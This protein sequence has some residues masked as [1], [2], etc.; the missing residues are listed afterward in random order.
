[1]LQY[2][3]VLLADTS[4]SYCHYKVKDKTTAWI[5]LANLKAGILFAMKQNLM[6]QFVY[7]DDDLPEGYKDLIGNIDHTNIMSS[8]APDR[9]R[10]DVLVTDRA[11]DLASACLQPDRECVFILHVCRD[12]LPV[13]ADQLV[14][15]LEKQGRVNLV[16][17]DVEQWKETEFELYRSALKKLS[18]LV[19]EQYHQG[20]ECQLNVL[21]DRIMLTGMN[22]CNAGDENI[23][24]GPDGKFYIC[25]AFYYEK[26]SSGDLINGLNILNPRLYKLPSAPICRN[27][28]AFQCK[29]CVWMNR[30]LT[31]EVNTP[32]HEQCVISHIERNASRDLWC[33]LHREGYARTEN[34]IP[35]IDYLD[36]FE[37][38]VN[39]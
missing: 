15:L 35:E 10:A 2:L 36:P 34:S 1:M 24:L 11:D 12:R 3:V 23:T 19:R 26:D 9:D 38:S 37:I 28:D 13:L 16:F 21:T 17:T 25:P 6:V 32:S 4:V 31:L 20:H 8:G 30:R 5:S 27:C 7:P 14:P 22:N 39:F 29:R 18:A 33:D